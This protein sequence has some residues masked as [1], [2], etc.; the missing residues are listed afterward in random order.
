M[1]HKKHPY[2]FGSF[3]FDSPFFFPLPPPPPPP[4]DLLADVRVLG[5][6][7]LDFEPAGAEVAEADV[8]KEEEEGGGG[9]LVA[10]VIVE[11]DGSDRVGC[12]VSVD[13][14]VGTTGVGAEVETREG[15]ASGREEDE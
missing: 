12:L 2:F 5:G 1:I 6:D 15:L 3:L 9:A 14:G 11:A 8:D 4:P 10:A 13:D 7:A